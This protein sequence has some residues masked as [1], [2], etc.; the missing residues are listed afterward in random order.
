MRLTF[1][2]LLI[3]IAF[4]VQAEDKSLKT[5]QPVISAEFKAAMAKADVDKGA[6]YFDKKCSTCHDAKKDGLHNMGP[7]L[8]NIAGRKAGG[9][10]G[11]DYSEA[12]KASG[13]TWDLAT[14]NHFLTNTKKAVPG[15]KM[16]FRG[17]RKEQDRANVIAYLLSAKD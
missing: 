12:M 1:L 3:A 13:H 17:I 2:S 7:N 11:F 10:A 5:Y 9:A 16:N 8:W 15:R 6:K 14:L 4:N